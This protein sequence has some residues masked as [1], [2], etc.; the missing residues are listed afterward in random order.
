MPNRIVSL[1]LQDGDV[2]AIDHRLKEIQ[3][4]FPNRNITRSEAIRSLMHGSQIEQVTVASLLGAHRMFS[5]LPEHLKAAGYK[6]DGIVFV[7][8]ALKKA[9]KVASEKLPANMTVR[10]IE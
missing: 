9:T 4:C 5:E 6:S 3:A 7:L 10:D 8:E 2:Q 1:N